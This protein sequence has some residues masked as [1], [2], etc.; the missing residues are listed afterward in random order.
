MTNHTDDAFAEVDA[1]DLIH[2]D[3]VPGPREDW[4]HDDVAHHIDHDALQAALEVQRTRRL[5]P[6]P[7][8]SFLEAVRRLG[9]A[10]GEVEARG[11]WHRDRDPE[12]RPYPSV[13]AWAVGHLGVDPIVASL[14]PASCREPADP[15]APTTEPARP[16]S[17]MLAA[18]RSEG[19]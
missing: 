14:F 19:T 15:S 8:E 18:R 11:V 13:A 1:A 3:D 10:L 7:R 17:E 6:D 5:S 2:D 12:G 4:P 16:T 9:R